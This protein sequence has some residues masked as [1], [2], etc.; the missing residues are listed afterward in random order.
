MADNNDELTFVPEEVAQRDAAA[1]RE[2]AEEVEKLEEDIKIDLE[3]IKHLTGDSKAWFWRGIM[4]GAGAI[5]GSI[6]MLIVLGWVLSILGII[7]GVS[8][9]SE[10]IRGYMDQ[11]H[12]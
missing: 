1:K 12:R 2:A 6:A 4:Q 7:P 8:E 9:I 3:E 5:V 10:Y 11:V